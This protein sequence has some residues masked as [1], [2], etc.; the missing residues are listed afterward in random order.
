MRRILPA[1]CGMRA[2]PWIQPYAAKFDR[3][4]GGGEAHGALLYPFLLNG[5]ALNPKFNLPDRGDR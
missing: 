4:S 3:V 2:P 5:V 1:S